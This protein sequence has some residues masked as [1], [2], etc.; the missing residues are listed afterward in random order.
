LVYNP[1]EREFIKYL[2]EQGFSPEEISKY[3]RILRTERKL[4]KQQPIDLNFLRK[5]D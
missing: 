5:P 2:H 4:S 1:H 3:L